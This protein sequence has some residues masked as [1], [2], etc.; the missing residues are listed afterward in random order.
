MDFIADYIESTYR[1]FFNLNFRVSLYYLAATIVLA[2]GIWSVRGRSTPFLQW[3]LPKRIYTH[4]SNLVD[5]KLFL[6]NRLFALVG[7]SSLLVFT[8]VVAFQTL[9][10]LTAVFRGEFEPQPVDS[11]RIALVTLLI[12]MVSD[13]CKYWS[14]RWQHKIK[15]LWP[16][17]AVHHSADVLTPVT[18]L[19]VHP[20][21]NMIRDLIISLVVGTLQGIVLF[22]VMGQISFVTIGGANAAYFL[23]NLF[24][25]NLRH[26][27]IWLSYGRVLE[28][29]FISP[30]QHQIHHSVALRHHD[31]NFGSIFALWDWMFGTLYIPDAEEDLVFGVSDAFG[32][33]I[34]QPHPSLRAALLKPFA[35][36]WAALRPA[37]SDNEDPV[38][39]P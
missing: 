36:S 10:V 11:V 1:L 38:T 22:A 7:L 13:F 35:D 2:L 8:P 25:A 34:D 14:H 31:K 29:V 4:R 26:S 28:H 30:A 23:F 21:E 20:V 19:R 33:P 16:F 39:D 37:H 15:S 12:V 3:L 17:H 5:I 6:A 18:V 24:G 32:D 9:V 27:H